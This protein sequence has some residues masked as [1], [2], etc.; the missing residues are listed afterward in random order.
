[1]L[2]CKYLSKNLPSKYPNILTNSVHPGFVDTKM[3]TKDIH[4]PYPFGGYAMSVGMR[5][6]KKDQW[7]GCISALFAATETEKSGQYICPPA[8]PEEGSALYRM[9]ALQTI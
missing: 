5:P 2:C 9:I 4:E 1:M 7:D 6:L 3:S 8:H